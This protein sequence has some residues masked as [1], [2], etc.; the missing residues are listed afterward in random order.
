MGAFT[1]SEDVIVAAVASSPDAEKMSVSVRMH[2]CTSVR[3]CLCI[4][5]LSG[6]VP[7]LSLHRRSGL[8]V[9]VQRR[10]KPAQL[11]GSSGDEVGGRDSTAAPQPTFRDWYVD[12]YVSAFAPDLLKAREEGAGGAADVALL[13]VATEDIVG[14]FSALEQ[15]VALLDSLALK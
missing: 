13:R 7:S 11:G 8:G 1:A 5:R 10:G 2:V 4:Q 6:A 3:L 12:S 9:S 14:M 15:R